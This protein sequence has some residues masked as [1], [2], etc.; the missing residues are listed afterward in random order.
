MGDDDDG[1][2]NNDDERK[3]YDKP[4]MKGIFITTFLF[5]CFVFNFHYCDPSWCLLF[6]F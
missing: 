5:L 6:I 3:D 1:D 2:W 4:S